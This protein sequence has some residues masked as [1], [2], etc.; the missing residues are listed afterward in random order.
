MSNRSHS[1]R[2]PPVFLAHG[3]TGVELHEPLWWHAPDW[4]TGDHTTTREVFAAVSHASLILAGL[5]QH[6]RVNVQTSARVVG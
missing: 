5:V 3:V 1:R 4:V 6:V 2:M